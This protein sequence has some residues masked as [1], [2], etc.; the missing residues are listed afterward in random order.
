MLRLTMAGMSE[1]VWGGVALRRPFAYCFERGCL[2]HPLALSTSRLQIFLA[3]E[4][5]ESQVSFRLESIMER[6][7]Q[8]KCL[9]FSIGPP[10]FAGSAT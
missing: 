1:E 3:D 10:Q 8:C 7:G 5:S 6:R 2:A 9:T 4:S